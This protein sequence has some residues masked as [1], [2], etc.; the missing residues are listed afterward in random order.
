MRSAL[1]LKQNSQ[2]PKHFYLELKT[3][4]TVLQGCPKHFKIGTS[5]VNVSQAY[6]LAAR[7]YFS[8][9]IILQENKNGTSQY[10]NFCRLKAEGCSQD[11]QTTS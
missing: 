5:C 11:S 10:N 8:N 3:S 2:N 4:D 6:A 9:R 7:N 1:T